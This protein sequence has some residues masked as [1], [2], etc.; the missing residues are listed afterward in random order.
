MSLSRL[1]PNTRGPAEEVKRRV[2]QQHG[3]LV[4]DVEKVPTTWDS[5]VGPKQSNSP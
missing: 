4:V 1:L 2:W 5:R 3:M